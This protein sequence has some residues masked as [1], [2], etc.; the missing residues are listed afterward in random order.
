MELRRFRVRVSPLEPYH[1]SPEAAVEGYGAFAWTTDM[2]TQY[3]NQETLLR[4]VPKQNP[5]CG[6]IK[7]VACI[8]P[9]T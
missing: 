1:R 7:S 6:A 4:L 8:K 9:S 3:T 5:L 2:D